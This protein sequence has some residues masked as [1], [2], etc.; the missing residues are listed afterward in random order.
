MATSAA[1]STHRWKA[2]SKKDRN[3]TTAH[4]GFTAADPFHAHFNA[5]LA[6]E[7]MPGAEHLS[8]AINHYSHCLH[9]RP[10]STETLLRL[11]KCIAAR[12][13]AVNPHR[14][15]MHRNG[16]GGG[17]GQQ[18][19]GGGSS[20]G[21][22]DDDGNNDPDGSLKI[23]IGLMRRHLHFLVTRD[24]LLTLADVLHLAGHVDES[25][26][27]FRRVADMSR[28]AGADDPLLKGAQAGL[29]VST[30]KQGRARGGDDAPLGALRTLQQIDAQ[31]R[32]RRGTAT[33]VGGR[34]HLSTL[35]FLS[36][37]LRSALPEPEAGAG[38]PLAANSYLRRTRLV[39]SPG[40]DGG[41]FY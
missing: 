29:M 30:H 23:A 36:R 32:R 38:V 8:A 14:N 31:Q 7:L 11:A 22:N 1:K 41:Y 6:K 37:S 21:G 39:N 18:E 27:L 28:G 10:A 2:K 34:Q 33:D 19:S 20:G 26:A 25:V 16:G 13:R 12:A 3:L 15:P 5:G 17:G 35:E 9:L 4:P 24:A 40:E